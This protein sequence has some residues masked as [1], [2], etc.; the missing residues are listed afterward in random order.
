MWGETKTPALNIDN[1]SK[2]TTNYQHV[3]QYRVPFF[4]KNTFLKQTFAQKKNE[5]N[6]T[7]IFS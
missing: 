3:L 6:K 2:I 1:I 7:Q 5:Q 4:L